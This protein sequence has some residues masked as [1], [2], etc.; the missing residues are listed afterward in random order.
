[1]ETLADFKKHLRRTYG[2]YLRAWRLVLSPN[3]SVTV[4]RTQFLTACSALGFKDAGKVLWRAFG[5][6]S[7]RAR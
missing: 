1:M 2:S 5:R 6:D 4:S 3:D 7:A